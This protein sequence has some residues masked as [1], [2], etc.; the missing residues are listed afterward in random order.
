MLTASLTDTY[1]ST[2]GHDAAESIEAKSM[3]QGGRGDMLLGG[4]G[5]AV[6]H[7]YALL[8]NATEHVEMY[9]HSYMEERVY[10]SV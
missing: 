2:Q 4:R 1:T 8:L 5:Q 7:L 10:S 9:T 6:E 3:F